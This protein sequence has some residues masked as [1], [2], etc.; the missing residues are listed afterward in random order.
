MQ[1]L[2]DA[3]GTQGLCF[4]KHNWFVGSSCRRLVGYAATD[5]PLPPGAVMHILV[6]GK[7]CVKTSTHGVS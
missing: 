4:D 5:Q 1:M 2:D 7:L 6:R 3:I